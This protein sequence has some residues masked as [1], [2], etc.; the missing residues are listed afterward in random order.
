MV[1]GLEGVSS[2]IKVLSEDVKNFFKEILEVAVKSAHRLRNKLVVDVKIGK[3][4]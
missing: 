1:T 2:E 3:V 4:K